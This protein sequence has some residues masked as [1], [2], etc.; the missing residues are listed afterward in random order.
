MGCPGGAAGFR[1]ESKIGRA[2]F[3]GLLDREDF[4]VIRP[5]V[6]VSEGTALEL[7]LGLAECYPCPSNV[8]IFPGPGQSS[9]SCVLKKQRT[10]AEPIKRRSLNLAGTR[11][12]GKQSLNGLSGF[13]AAFLL[14]FINPIGDGLNHFAR[15]LR[16]RVFF[17]DGL[18]LTPSLV[19]LDDFDSFLF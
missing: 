7:Q 11:A 13:R 1:I 19:L 8:S 9:A 3:L 15:S 10:E 6:K 2:A 17:G 18:W 5:P 14:Q 16:R 12:L 4:I